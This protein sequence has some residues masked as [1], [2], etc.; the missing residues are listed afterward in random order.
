MSYEGR[1]R[2]RRHGPVRREVRRRSARADAWAISRSNCAAAPTSAAPATSAFLKI[3]SEAG[4]AA[5]VRRIEAVT[6]DNACSWP[7]SGSA[8]LERH[9]RH[10]S[11]ANAGVARVKQVVERSRELEKEID[12]LKAKLASSAGTIVTSRLAR[13]TSVARCWHRRNAGRG[14]PKPCARPGPVEEQ[15]SNAAVV[16]LATVKDEQGEPVIAG[17]TRTMTATVKA[18]DLINHVARRSAARAAVARTWP[19]PAA[20]TPPCSKKR[21]A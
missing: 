20:P 17:V 11:R 16:V 12:R 4:V 5:G 7:G 3:V 18:G 21:C 19:R 14:R 13:R 1:H 9:G 8:Q 15:V 2:K 6:G 10:W